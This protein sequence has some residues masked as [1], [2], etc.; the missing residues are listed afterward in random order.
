MTVSTPNE[1]FAVYAGSFD[2]PTM[3]HRR[4]ILTAARLFER[5]Y[6]LVAPNAAKV[7]A[8]SIDDRVEILNEM[9]DEDGR[10]RIGDLLHLGRVEVQALPEGQFVAARAAELGC[11]F[12]VRGVRGAGDFEPELALARINDLAAP[13]VTTLFLTAPKQVV[14][15]SSSTVRGLVGLLG[16]RA[17]V[18]PMVPAATMRALEKRRA[19]ELLEDR[20]LGLNDRTV[21]DSMIHRYTEPHRVYHTL[22]HIIDC[23]EWLRTVH[24]PVMLDYWVYQRLAV[25]LWFHDAVYDPRATDNEEAS[26]ALLSVHV[27]ASFRQLILATKRHFDPSFEP[28]DLETQLMLDIDL[29][30]FAAPPGESAYLSAAIRLEYAHVPLADYCKARVELLTLLLQKPRI[31]R[32]EFFHE[33]LEEKARANIA[34]EIHRL[35]RD[36]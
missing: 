33:R 29:A 8:F 36:P 1:R 30:S 35:T 25:A 26:L 21:W 6:V 3:G 13:E 20:W 34:M 10:N 22:G 9:L 15:V 16:W 24:N 28:T 18:R 23:L 11:A 7:S 32:T 31:Y 17:I 12:L 4:V 2:P 19:R 14:D 5:V 27:G